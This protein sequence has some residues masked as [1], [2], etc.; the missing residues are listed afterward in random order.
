V[1]DYATF[2]GAI[3]FIIGILLVGLSGNQRM[4]LKPLAFS[5]GALLMIAGAAAEMTA[6]ISSRGNS[7]TSDGA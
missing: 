4:R 6:L 5:I 2:L 1:G 3:A 7:A